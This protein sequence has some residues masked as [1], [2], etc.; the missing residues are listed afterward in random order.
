M[1]RLPQ[2]GAAASRRTT[3]PL[4]ADPRASRRPPSGAARPPAPEPPVP[5]VPA[6]G[7]PAPPAPVLTAPVVVVA[8]PTLLLESP[9]PEDVVPVVAVLLV[10]ELAP[11][12]PRLESVPS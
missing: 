11:P 9:V 3:P 7:P 10:E 2:P 5:P 12:A 4:P 1:P 6:A 8:G